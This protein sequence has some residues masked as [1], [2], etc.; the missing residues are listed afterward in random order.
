M[1]R[2][3]CP[4]RAPPRR[5]AVHSETSATP[6]SRAVAAG[7]PYPVRSRAGADSGAGPTTFQSRLFHPSFD[8]QG[9]LMPP[10]HVSSTAWEGHRD[11]V[12]AERCRAGHGGDGRRLSAGRGAACPYPERRPRPESGE[13]TASPAGRFP[14]RRCGL[15]GLPAL[16][17]TEQGQGRAGVESGKSAGSCGVPVRRRGACA[18]GHAGRLRAPA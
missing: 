9:G 6:A 17:V 13:V 15:A 4:S 14:G 11:Q 8:D 10:D 2:S 3:T 16:A 12:V 1:S 5:T 18:S 7:A